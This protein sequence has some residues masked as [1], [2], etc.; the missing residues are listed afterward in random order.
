M[1]KVLVCGKMDI[2]SIQLLSILAD[3]IH[4]Y[5]DN[6]LENSY[7]SQAQIL[8][9]KQITDEKYDAV[10]INQGTLDKPI[11]NQELK[12]LIEKSITAGATM[13]VYERSDNFRSQIKSPRSF[14]S[15]LFGRM[16]SQNPELSST[17]V[18]SIS[19]PTISYT[20]DPHESVTLGRYYSNKNTFL[21]KERLKI[22]FLSTRLSNFF[23]NGNIRVWQSAKKPGSLVNDILTALKELNINWMGE[24]I[25]V[26]KIVYRA[27]KIIISLASTPSRTPEYFAI[28]TIDESSRLQREN[29]ERAIRFL[30]KKPRFKKFVVTS[31]YSH[32]VGIFKIF[33]MSE[34]N[35]ITVD[36][37]NRQV[38]EMT[39]NVFE[40]L[41]CLT[42]EYLTLNTNNNLKE[43]ASSYIHE[44]KNR[45]PE[46]SDELAT[47]TSFVSSMEFE[48]LPTV[49]MHGDAKLE[50][51]ILNQKNSVQ[52]VIDFELTEIEGFPLLDLFFLFAY[53]YQIKH[54]C[55]F[56]SAFE[57]LVNNDLSDQESEM[58]SI[59]CR[60]YNISDNQKSL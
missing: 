5:C 28:L 25:E 49:F 58:L 16:N 29:E 54:N 11:D 30:Q 50:N 6:K 33:V 37:D 35:G 55:R 9:R 10:I 56:N 60:K 24:S 4:L 22:F 7:A 26:L 51:F 45:Y 46:F 1:N 13:C 32:P 14:L 40:F 39:Q 43:L 17:D 12:L 38:P 31:Y 18:Q 41:L 34:L 15:N 20:A 53:N 36:F 21:L 57:R 59:Y 8:D 19:Y 2:Y 44:F 42:D 23:T 48:K 52:G 3:Q 27:G 47:I